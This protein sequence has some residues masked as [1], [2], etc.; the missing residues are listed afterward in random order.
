MSEPGDLRTSRKPDLYGSKGL[1]QI[2]LEKVL[3]RDMVSLIPEIWNCLD[4]VY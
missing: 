4:H 1:T 2:L 3:S